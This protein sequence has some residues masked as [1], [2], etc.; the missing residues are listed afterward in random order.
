MNKVIAALDG[1]KPSES[2]INYAIY[3]AKEFDA[4]IVAVFLEDIIYHPYPYATNSGEEEV[5]Y[6]TNVENLVATE[7]E[8]RT[9]SIKK[10]QKRFDA[11]GVHHNIHRDKFIAMESLIKESHFADMILIDVNERFSQ[12]D[13]SIPSQF[14][15]KLMAEADCPLMLV[16]NEFK[17]IEKIV[18]AYDGSPS[19]AYAIRHF[20]YLFPVAEEQELEILMITQNKHNNHFPEQK[21]LKE[22]L[23]TKYKVVLQ[24]IIRSDNPTDAMIAHLKD[25]TKNCM[26]ILGAYQRSALSRWLHESTADT[27]ISSSVDIPLFIAHK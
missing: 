8:I 26:V 3:L 13:D 24:C 11:E 20:S 14:I 7:E 15:K 1:F 23:K 2:T 16:P 10:L 4:H 21:L 18:F 5:D 6:S 17:P 12:W 27:L 25:E 9:L 19:S 22:L